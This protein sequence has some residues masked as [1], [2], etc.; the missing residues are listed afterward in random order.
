MRSMT[1][2]EGVPTT[3]T[4]GRILKTRRTLLGLTQVEAA[5]RLGVTQS[6]YNRWE[7]ERAVPEAESYEAA[8]RFLEL[9][10]PTFA[11]YLAESKLRIHRR[12]LAARQ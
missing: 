10:F 3:P 12:D 9:D 1:H 6:T 11:H 4:I 7:L 5:Q 8:A 2:S